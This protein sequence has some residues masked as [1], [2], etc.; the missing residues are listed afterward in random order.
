MERISL[1]LAAR[2][3]LHLGLVF[4]VFK[5]GDMGEELV[6]PQNRGKFW[7]ATAT[8]IVL[9]ETKRNLPGNRR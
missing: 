4:R 5:P 2:L 6:H 9:V 1:V 3:Q 8:F 7:P